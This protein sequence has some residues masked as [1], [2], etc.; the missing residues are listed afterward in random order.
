MS[1]IE[2]SI[3]N[4]KFSL[5][6]QMISLLLS[7]VS[8]TV[9][10]R[11]LSAEYLGLN[12]LFTNVLSI[13]SLAELGVGT[14]IIY[15]L[16]EPLAKN[17][18]YRLKA[19]MRIFRNVYITVGIWMFVAGLALT[20]FLDFFIKDMPDIP[21]INLIYIM[22]VANSATSYFFSYKR[23]LVIA[24]QKKYID[25]FYHFVSLILIHLIQIVVLVLTKNYILF[26]TVRIV[27][28]FAEN[29]LIT[30]KAN[31]LYPYLKKYNGEKLEADDK[32]TI[33]KNIKALFFHRI[34][35][36]AV[37]GTDNLL[38]SKFV[39]LISVGL[40]SNYL[41]ITASLTMVYKLIFQSLIASVGN[42]GVSEDKKRLISVFKSVDFFGFWIFGFSSIALFI[43]FNPFIE[44][45]LGEEY[46]FEMPIVFLISLNFYLKGMRTGVLTFKDA[47]GLYYQDRYK[48]LIEAVINLSASIFL[49][50]NF[51]VAGVLIGTTISTLTTSFWVE[52]YV[53]YKYGFNDK[54]YHYFKTYVLRSALAFGIG[55]VTYLASRLANGG[56][57]MEF[58]LKAVITAVIP[59]LFFLIIFRKKEEFKYI[60]KALKR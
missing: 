43:L 26:L 20:P 44:L 39:S 10:V 50:I 55:Y 41:M 57:L 6:G 34:G 21:N 46:L 32:K 51:G 19:L 18:E 11:Y 4:V 25:S 53:L 17:Q 49:A 59:N 33:V 56:S 13:L 5:G 2:N 48:P 35:T 8:R 28:S 37:T 1:R 7:F 22:F 38:M 45:W 15:S 31:K 58:A 52:P 29:Y 40:Y 30:L 12:G 47:L 23:S 24:D 60:I 14:A 36:I 3:K 42:L 16:Y 9:F 54:I 27:G